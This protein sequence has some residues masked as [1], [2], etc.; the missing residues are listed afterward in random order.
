MRRSLFIV[1][2]LAA[3]MSPAQARQ[4]HWHWGHHSGAYPG[5]AYGM[6]PADP[7]ERRRQREPGLADLVPPGWQLQPPDEHWKGKRF[8]SPDGSA[9]LAAYS[10]SVTKETI[11]SHMQTVAFADGEALTYLRGEQDWI[12]VSGL[13]GDRIFYRKAVIACGGR[14][15]HH[16][17]FEY[18]AG[19]KRQMDPFVIRAAGLIDQTENDGC[20][21]ATSS[22]D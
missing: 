3:A 8:V 21:E 6:A 11:A 22:T 10:A 13:K 7:A 2:M 14:V 5:G 4:W 18:P 12:A 20:D 15:W 17:A 9:W 1:L 16:F 19:M